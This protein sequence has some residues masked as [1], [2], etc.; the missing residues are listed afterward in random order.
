MA[1]AEPPILVVG[2][3]YAHG[4]EVTDA[5]DLAGAAAGR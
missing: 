5:R 2:N 4:D 1:L 3:S